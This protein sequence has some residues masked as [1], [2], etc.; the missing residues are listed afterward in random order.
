MSRVLSVLCAALLAASVAGAQT[1]PS[2]RPIKI[3]PVQ[4]A[5][6]VQA[7][8]VAPAPADAAVTDQAAS[9][10]Q[11]IETMES[12]QAANKQLRESN[13]LLRAENTALKDR[14]TALTTPGGSLV[15]AYCPTRTLSRNTAG[16]ESDCSSSGYTCEDVSGL[17]RTTCQSSDMCAGGYTCDVG[18]GRCIYTAGGVP[19]SDG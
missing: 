19:D 4:P 8:Q 18:A 17:C 3:Q 15:R 14:I 5:P 9:P 7:T 1:V 13:K 11:P 10:M 12:L 6:A 16:A 2:V